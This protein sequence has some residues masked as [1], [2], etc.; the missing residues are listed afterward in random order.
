MKVY[1]IEYRTTYTTSTLVAGILT[2]SAGSGVRSHSTQPQHNLIW[3]H[4]D[5]RKY[6][7]KPVQQ[8]PNIP[9]KDSSHVPF[10]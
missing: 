1:G 9:K 3:L 7:V 4:L 2:L 6:T 5:L 8:P 10:S